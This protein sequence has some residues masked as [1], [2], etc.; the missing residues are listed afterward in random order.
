MYV[1]RMCSYIY[2]CYMF[3][4][5]RNTI[6]YHVHM[7]VYLIEN[8]HA[9]PPH[10]DVLWDLGAMGRCMVCC[11]SLRLGCSV[12]W[13]PVAFGQDFRSWASP[14]L[15]IFGHAWVSEHAGALFRTFPFTTWSSKCTLLGHVGC[16]ASS[17]WANSR[18]RWERSR[19]RWSNHRSPWS[20]K[21]PRLK[22][23][24]S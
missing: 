19:S 9:S 17:R 15:M 2:I 10:L 20:A 4:T 14:L 22:A 18:S 11:S 23:T 6:W 12:S 1:Y 13:P 24:W 5:P 7:Y 8:A 21:G 3:I 16:K